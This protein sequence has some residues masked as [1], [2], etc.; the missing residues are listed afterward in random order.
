MTPKPTLI[1]AI[2]EIKRDLK[3]RLAEF[4]A[5]GKLLEVQRL[6]QRTRFDI[7]M[8]AATGSCAGIKNYSAT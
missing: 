2:E 8:I 6:E 3:L 4:E 7:E 1:Q 5:Q